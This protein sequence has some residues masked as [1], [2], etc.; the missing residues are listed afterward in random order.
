MMNDDL[1]KMP[2]LANIAGSIYPEIERMGYFVDRQGN[3]TP[4]ARESLLYKMT[5]SGLVRSVE[6]FLLSLSSLTLP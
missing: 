4:K 5:W 3:P 2:Q 6:P 1:A